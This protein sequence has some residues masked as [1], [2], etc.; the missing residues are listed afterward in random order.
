[1]SAIHCNKRSTAE[2][3]ENNMATLLAEQ[4]E[5]VTY[6]FQGNAQKTNHSL[7]FTEFSIAHPHPFFDMCVHN[8]ILKRALDE[9]C[10]PHVS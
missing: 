3:A 1:M 5:T 8:A 7:C 10:G 4:V 9:L 6:H 2:L